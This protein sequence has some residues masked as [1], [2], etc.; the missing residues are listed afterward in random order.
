MSNRTLIGLAAAAIATLLVMVTLSAVTGISQETFE[1]VLSPADYSAG[2]RDHALLLRALFG[3]DSAFLILYASLI[4]GF[5]LRYVTP[6]NRV[7]IGVAIGA[8]VLTALL[9]M[10]EDHHIL[11]LMRGALRGI[12]ATSDQ[13]AFEHTLSQTKFHLGYFAEFLL[14]LHIVR[15]SRAATVLAVLLTVGTLLQGAWLYAAPDAMLPM[16]NF[17]RWA[18][19]VVGFA[20]IIQIVRRSSSAAA[21]GAPA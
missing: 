16:G 1:I 9:D 8:I 15:S 11:A 4:T 12:D 20:L 10:I 5:A 19:F 17:L 6:Q 3:L 18:G 7:L 13:I 14:G 2:L 21:T